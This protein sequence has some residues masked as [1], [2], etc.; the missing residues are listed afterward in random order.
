[1]TTMNWL[2]Q[3]YVKYA[4]IMCAVVI[5]C[6]LLMHATGQYTDFDTQSPFQITF[7]L[8]P[9]IVWFLGLNARKKELKGKLTFTQGVMEGFKIS[10]IF[11]IISPFIFAAYYLLINPEILKYVRTSYGMTGE[12]DG[13]VIMVDMLVQFVSALILGT[14]YGAILSVFLKTKS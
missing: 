1:M 11:S 12:A 9:F 3:N 6:L 4:L 8:A 5:V 10:L 13:M 14:L 2:K 7:L